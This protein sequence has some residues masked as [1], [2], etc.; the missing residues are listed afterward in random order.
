MASYFRRKFGLVLTLQVE[1]ETLNGI[2]TMQRLSLMEAQQ[3]FGNQ[4]SQTMMVTVC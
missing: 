4:V 1:E 2:V 3:T